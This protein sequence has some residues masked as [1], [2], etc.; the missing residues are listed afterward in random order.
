MD[1]SPFLFLFFSYHQVSSLLYQ[2]SQLP[3][4]QFPIR[5]QAMQTIG[6]WTE[7]CKP[8]EKI[9]HLPP[10]FWYSHRTM[11]STQ[12]DVTIG[13]L[14]QDLQIMAYGLILCQNSTVRRRFHNTSVLSGK[15]GGFKNQIIPQLLLKFCRH[16]HSLLCFTNPLIHMIA[17]NSWEWNGVLKRNVIKERSIFLLWK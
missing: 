15:N 11:T 17:Q 4:A 8:G 7:P 10:I 2:F 9:K 6:P 5:P 16:F 14:P 1:P 3:G 13:P 12:G